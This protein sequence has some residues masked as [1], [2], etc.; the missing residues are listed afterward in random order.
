M[1]YQSEW[2]ITPDWFF[3]PDHDNVAGPTNSDIH[4]P[5][6][7]E[8]FKPGEV[9]YGP[10]DANGDGVS[11]IGPMPYVYEHVDFFGQPLGIFSDPVPMAVKNINFLLKATPTTQQFEVKGSVFADL[12]NDGAF[13]GNDALL[14]Q[15]YRVCGCE[16]QRFLRARR[17][18]GRDRRQRRLHAPDSIELAEHVLRSAC[19]FPGSIGQFKQPGTGVQD[20]ILPQQ[21]SSAPA[22][23][24][25]LTPPA[26]PNPSNPPPGSLGKVLGVVFND[27]DGDG[28]RDLNEP[29]AIGVRV[30]VDANKDG[31]WQ[32]TEVNAFTAS[33]GSFVLDNVT[34]GSNIWIDVDIANEGTSNAAVDLDATL[35]GRRWPPRGQRIRR[36][37][38]LR[39]HVWYVRPDRRRLGRFAHCKLWRPTMDLTTKSSPGFKLGELNSGEVNG[40]ASATSTA[41]TDDGVVVVGGVLKPGVNTL[42]VTVHGVGGVLTGWMDFNGDAG[43]DGFSNSEQLIWTLNG[44]ASATKRISIREPTSCKSRSRRCRP[45]ESAADRGSVPLG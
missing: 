40:M 43:F 32:S 28:F 5:F 8:L 29:G 22:L 7:G 9:L 4:A 18:V 12:N 1:N 3:A 38:E 20:V 42:Q 17:D 30:F 13:N 19:G 14:A 27:L 10:N 41:D 23:N 2:T 25:A 24:F 36:R 34:P 31:I 39:R 44:T 21:V 33:N 16:S 45:C 37:Y 11:T 6:T 35:G 26:T 15:R